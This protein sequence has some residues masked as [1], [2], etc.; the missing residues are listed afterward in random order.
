M[1]EF[2]DAAV[3]DVNQNLIFDVE[4]CS[5]EAKTERVEADDEI[6]FSQICVLFSVALGAQIFVAQLGDRDG[7]ELGLNG[8][9]YL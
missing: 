3:F 6:E 7:N 1:S 9:T 8:I 2:V 5:I 4:G